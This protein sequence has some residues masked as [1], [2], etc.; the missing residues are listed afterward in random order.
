MTSRTSGPLLATLCLICALPAQLWGQD[1]QTR[2][3]DEPEPTSET[4]RDP[5]DPMRAARRPYRALFGGAS[6]DRE[7]ASGTRLNG[8]IFQVWDENLLA[9][10][11]PPSPTTTE[12]QLSG[13]YL[14]LLGDLNYVRRG[15]RL[16]LAATGGANARY[17]TGLGKFA[18]NNYH[19][20]VGLSA[21]PSPLLTISANQGVSYAPVFLFGLFAQALPPTLGDV[22]SPDSIFAVNDDRAL[23][24]D[25][26][27][28]VERR[29]SARTLLNGKVG[30]RR[31]HYLAVTPR[32][33]DF[34]TI[35]A[36][37][38]LRY[39][40]TED[41]DFRVGYAYRNA[42]FTGSS[43]FGPIPQ[44]PVEHNLHVGVAF[45]PSLSE[46]RRTILTFE[47]GTS[48]V[49]AAL[50]TNQFVTR[51]QLRLVGDISLAHQM[52]RTWLLVGTFKRGTGFVQGLAG[53]VFTDAVSMTTSGFLHPRVDVAASIGYS[54]G[55]PSL[56]GS[57]IAF[58]TTTADARLRVAL[59]TRWAF[60]AE[61]LF[62]HYDFSQV[63]T[64]FVSGLDPRVKR[65]VVRGG[66]NLWLPVRR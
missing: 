6:I 40:L 36:G 59:S 29:F 35:D 9:E 24:V 39:R 8:S 11:A 22:R 28:E 12:L 19:T 54:N 46:Q 62:Y 21:R 4:E 43:L 63:L 18:A 60:T 57:V 33:T 52:G 41:N 34:S 44:Q 56:V 20:E 64:T 48:L 10:L 38:G 26:G 51:R 23:N 45:H 5:S 27:A 37:G 66:I 16:Q 47:G 17:Y 31:S 1:R 50:A 49:N 53:P 13:A 7:P 2:P 61:Y 3:R 65:N 14:N 15:T 30:Y 25:S 55:E 32:G 42:T 58:S